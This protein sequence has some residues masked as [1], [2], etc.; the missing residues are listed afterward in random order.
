MDPFSFTASLLTVS[1]FVAASCK[2]INDL[3]V[4]AGNVP[5]CVERLSQQIKAL[6]DL[7][8]EMEAESH[9][10]ENDVPL[11]EALSLTWKNSLLLMKQD[12]KGLH[13]ILAEVK[14]SVNDKSPSSK[15]LLIV[16]KMLSEKQV[17]E[18]QREISFHYHVLTNIQTIVCK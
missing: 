13:D 18:Y 6:Q 9:N 15:V 4:K 14:R 2:I 5:E 1:G 12:V 16:R 17:A 7:S 11:Q 3:R 8:K 10:F